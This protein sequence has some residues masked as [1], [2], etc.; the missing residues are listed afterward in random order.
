MLERTLVEMARAKAN[1]A[2][3]DAERTQKD[4]CLL[5]RCG[6]CYLEERW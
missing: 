1:L 4:A 3:I 6:R 5:G 2:A